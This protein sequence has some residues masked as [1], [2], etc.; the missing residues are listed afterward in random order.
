MPARLCQPRILDYRSRNQDHTVS[1]REV[2]QCC[3]AEV[4]CQQIS[5]L[6][7][8][9]SHL[10]PLY[11][12]PVSH[13]K[14]LTLYQPWYNSSSR[15]SYEPCFCGFACGRLGACNP[16]PCDHDELDERAGRFPP[17]LPLNSQAPAQYSQQ[18][19]NKAGT[20]AVQ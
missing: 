17:T 12:M 19:Y 10:L 6:S 3:C 14:L 4:Q 8:C 11:I 5:L 16:E 15:D 9:L 20:A 2:Q 1:R 13:R 7:F 18:R